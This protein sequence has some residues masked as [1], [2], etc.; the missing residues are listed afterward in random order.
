MEME[1]SLS[2]FNMCWNNHMAW[3]EYANN[4]Q[5]KINEGRFE[6][7]PALTW[8]SAY[9]FDDDSNFLWA[10]YYL[11]KNNI[12]FVIIADIHIDENLILTDLEFNR[13]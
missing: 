12:P 13:E 7:K 5:I 1:M 8:K 10:R 4:W 6:P 3:A 2:D 9:W 11:I